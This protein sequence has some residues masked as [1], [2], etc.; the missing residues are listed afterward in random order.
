MLCH[1][2]F[3]GEAAGSRENQHL[4]LYGA[5][6]YRRHLRADPKGGNHSGGSPG[7]RS[8]SGGTAALRGQSPL[9][10]HKTITSKG[11]K[12]TRKSEKHCFYD[13]IPIKLG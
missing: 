13:N 1:L 7:H 10:I 2:E 5:G 3:R 11:R 9:K 12:K 8:D 6:D 4:H